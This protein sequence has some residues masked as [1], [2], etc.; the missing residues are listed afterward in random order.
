MHVLVVTQPRYHH[1]PKLGIFIRRQF[2]TGTAT[3]HDA[4]ELRIARNHI[5]EVHDAERDVVA[6][7]RTHHFAVLLQLEGQQHQAGDDA[8]ARREAHPAIEVVKFH[9]DG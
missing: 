9:G 1:L 7:L 6:G 2:F 3:E 4:V 5:H 8:Q